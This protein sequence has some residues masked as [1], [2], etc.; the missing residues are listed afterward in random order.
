[1]STGKLHYAWLI[2]IACCAISSCAGII[3][4]ASSNLYLPISLE[5]GVG[6]GKITFYVTIL[7]LTMA[8]LFPTAG[9]FLNLNLKATLLFGG[10]CEYIALGVMSLYHNVYLFYVSGFFIGVGMSI[11]L[12]MAI[13]MLLNMWFEKRLGLA[14]GIAMACNG[15][16]GALFSQVIGFALPIIGWRSCYILLAVCG[17]AIYLPAILF[18]VKTPQQK[19][20]LPYGSE[21]EKIVDK[22]P[23]SAEQGDLTTG[24]LLKLPAFICMVIFGVV[25]AAAQSEIPHIATA[26]SAH[27][28]YAVQMAATMVSLNCV[29]LLIGNVLIGMINDRLGEKTTVTL[30]IGLVILS[31]V[32]LIMGR[33]SIALVFAGVFL[34]GFSMATYNVIAPLMTGT[35]FGTKNY[36]TV[37]AFICS[38]ASIAGAIAPPVFG[39]TYDFTGSYTLMFYLVIGLSVIGLVSG[40]IALQKNRIKH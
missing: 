9:K 14:M 23:E 2:M 21:G 28:G 4:T 25:L 17:L 37:W 5:L 30:G 19:G 40:L 7:S 39:L 1:M 34:F 32:M 20:M 38:A 12:Y 33:A 10:L 22:T 18:L 16:S 24:Q 27:F 8:V 11:T 3:M 31:Q 35:I 15:V 36:N 13:P 29:G 26:S 6:I